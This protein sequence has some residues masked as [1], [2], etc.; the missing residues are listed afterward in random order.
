VATRQGTASV[1]GVVNYAL[2]ANDGCPAGTQ[3]TLAAR[4]FSGGVFIASAN[5]VMVAFN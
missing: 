3:V 1:P 4:V 2:A 5:N